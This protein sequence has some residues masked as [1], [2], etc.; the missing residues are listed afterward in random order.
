MDSIQKAVLNN[1]QNLNLMTVCRPVND[2][3]DIDVAILR[4]LLR[5]EKSQE[6]ATYLQTQLKLALKWNR[7]DIAKKFIFTEENTDKVRIEL[8]QLI[9]VNFH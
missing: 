4:A 5:K 1:E 7:I 9:F 3:A 8:K 2:H 6:S